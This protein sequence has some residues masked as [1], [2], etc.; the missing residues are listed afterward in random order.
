RAASTASCSTRP[1]PAWA[2]WPGAR[3]RAG[4]APSRPRRRW[5]G[6]SGACSSMPAACSR[7]AAGSCTR[8][9][10]SGATSATGS[11]PA[12]A[13]RSRTA[14][15]PTA[16]TWRSRDARYSHAD[17]LLA[18]RRAGCALDPLLRLRPR[19]RAGLGGHGCGCARD[20]HRRDGRPLRARDHLRAEDGRR[21]RRHDPRARRVRRRP[22]DDR[23]AGAAPGPVRRGGRRQHHRPRRDLPAPALHAPD[24]P[25]PRLPGRRHAEPGHAG[26]GDRRGGPLRRRA[27]VHEREP[28]LGRS[29]LHPGDARPP[30]E[31]AG[32]RGGARRRRGRGRRRHPRRDDRRRPRGRREHPRRRLGRLRRAQPRRGLSRPGRAAGA[33]RRPRVVIDAAD[34]RHLARCSELAERGRRTAAPNPVVGAV[35]VRDG[36]VVGEG[37]HERPGGHHAEVAALRAAGDAHGATV[38]VSLEPCSHHGRTPPCADA[39]VAAGVARMRAAGVTVDVAGGE[40]ERAARRQNARWLTFALLGRP[41]VT[42]KAAV[43]A[44]GRTASPTGPRWI[45]SPQSRAQ[46][47]ELRAQMGAVAVG[48]GT[49]MADDPLLTARDV[50]PPAE[51]QP[52]RVVFDHRARLPEGSRLAATAAPDAPVLVFAAPGAVPVAAPGVETLPVSTAAEALAELGRRRISALLLEGGATLATGLLDAGLIDRLM[53]YRAPIE[54]GD[55]PGLFTRDVALPEPW[56][57]VP[58]GPDILTLTEL[59]E[60]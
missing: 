49:V 35:V 21:R 37:W 33:R 57:T 58:S 25:R 7:P 6:C 46:V 9:A 54:L 28:G 34:R 20:P 36:A 14:I 2:S 53:L 59:R 39:L 43:S 12:A 41:H 22:P 24:D 47:H 4:G 15:T 30:A 11:S 45:S 17:A 5:P 40:V 18:P 60:A 26:R 42:Y 16:S 29:E 31:D 44:D 8:S 55:G 10:R 56:S 48:I 13:R 50:D 23:G 51:R 27:A 38:Y 1:A 3:T 52:V 32:V 19:A